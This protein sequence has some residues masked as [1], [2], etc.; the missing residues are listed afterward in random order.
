MANPKEDKKTPS[1]SS[2]SSTAAL[3]SYNCF[4]IYLG[5]N[6]DAARI[7]E[8]ESFRYSVQARPGRCSAQ[9]ERAEHSR[10]RGLEHVR[11]HALRRSDAAAA[12]AARARLLYRYA[13]FLFWTDV[14]KRWMG[15][16]QTPRAPGLRVPA[17][18]YGHRKGTSWSACAVS[19]ARF[20][21]FA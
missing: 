13:A 2:S 16:S 10:A 1:S 11:V 5:E 9:G 3:V 6:V 18:V 7:L 15:L 20:S 8:F 14:E 21:A 17:S 19:Q 4:F 12:L